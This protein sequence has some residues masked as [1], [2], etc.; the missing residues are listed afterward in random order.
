[1][2]RTTLEVLEDHLEQRGAGRIL[3]DLE[4]NYAP[5]IVLLCE[6]GVHCGHDGV[7]ESAEKLWLQLPDAKFEYLAMQ[8]DRE[9]ALLKWRGESA[10]ARA[11]HG[12]DS[13]VIRD[14]KIVMQSIYYELQAKK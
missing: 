11:E 8:V 3:D 13:F 2:A 10:G 9:F 12:V 5:N 1:M 7:R 6:W 14:G 4:R